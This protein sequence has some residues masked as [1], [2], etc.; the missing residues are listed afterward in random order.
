MAEVHNVKY[1]TILDISRIVNI[2]NVTLLLSIILLY[3]RVNKYI[4]IT[5]ILIASVILSLISQK[6]F[7][8]RFGDR[9][10]IIKSK[11][12]IMVTVILNIIILT[13]YV[14]VKE[15][16][17]VGIIVIFYIIYRRWIKRKI[18]GINT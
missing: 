14:V 16:I 4:S 9:N 10:L 6:W 18:K 8:E 7:V 2:I 1:A 17:L 13:Y 15:Y 5:I 11:I 12:Y 3:F